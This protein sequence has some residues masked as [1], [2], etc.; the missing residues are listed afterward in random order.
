MTVVKLDVHLSTVDL[1]AVVLIEN[2][3]DGSSIRPWKV[4]NI[5]LNIV[6][7]VGQSDEQ[8]TSSEGVEVVGGVFLLE[9]LF[10]TFSLFSSL[11]DSSGLLIKVRAGVHVLPE[12]LS[13]VWI[14]TT[15]IGLLTTVV[16]E[17]NTSG[18]HGEPKS[19]GEHVLVVELVQESSVVVVVNEDTKGI[20]ILEVGLFF[21]VS[22]LDV[23][24]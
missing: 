6:I 10:V 3:A 17:W 1:L 15:G 5:V 24:H 13:I 18:S 21:L 9:R 14:V 4:W 2:I 19:T 8:V 12:R 22:V 20:D 16:V 11:V 23:V 7:A